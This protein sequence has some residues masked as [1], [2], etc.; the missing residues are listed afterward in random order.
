MSLRVEKIAGHLRGIGSRNHALHIVDGDKHVFRGFAALF[1]AGHA[2]LKR[3]ADLR[4]QPLQILA[5]LGRFDGEQRHAR[6]GRSAD[7]LLAGKLVHQ[8]EC[9]AH[10][11]H[12]A[13]IRGIH[14][15]EH[16][17]IALCAV[18]R[19]RFQ[20]CFIIEGKHHIRQIVREDG[21]ALRL[22]LNGDFVDCH[23]EIRGSDA[24][25]DV[26]GLA[27]AREQHPRRQNEDAK[28]GNPPP[29]DG[30]IRLLQL[31]ISSRFPVSR[32]KARGFRRAGLC[33][34]LSQRSGSPRRTLDSASL[35]NW[36][37]HR[38][39]RPPRS[40]AQRSASR[41]SSSR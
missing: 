26:V 39:E 14:D 22:L 27:A 36:R 10:A 15:G 34:F 17:Q 31:G 30:S 9:R 12:C 32:P 40:V 20:H 18:R 5:R 29:D 7:F 1:I 37:A 25:S 35:M 38:G 28:Q 11:A 13:V 41:S 2:A 8:R 33:V 21:H 4:I 16:F 23:G 6:R 19:A 3:R 24:G